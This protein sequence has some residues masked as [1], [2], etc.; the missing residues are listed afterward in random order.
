MK[1]M[2]AFAVGALASLALSAVA[3]ERGYY[4]SPDLHEDILV[5]VSEGDLWRASAQ[6]GTAVRLTTHPEAESAP[7]L[8]PDGNW[9]AFMASYDGP[10][11]VY[12][13]SATGGSPKRL[14]HEG[15][16]VS[17]RGW[18]DNERVI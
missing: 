2:I 7:I 11:E 12:L 3:Q 14:T 6:G 9:I 10:E 5:F 13:I 8:S 16:G 4:Q 15:G 18:K 1:T 17:L